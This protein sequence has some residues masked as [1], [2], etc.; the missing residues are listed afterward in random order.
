M[1]FHLIET[2]KKK[3]YFTTKLV[4][5]DYE[6]INKTIPLIILILLVPLPQIDNILKF[7]S[8]RNNFSVVTDKL[9]KFGT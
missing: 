5:S 4:E 3:L 9:P 8:N 6:P 1:T 7:F 2:E